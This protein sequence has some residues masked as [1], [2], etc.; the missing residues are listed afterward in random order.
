MQSP[1]FTIRSEGSFSC[2]YILRK[3]NNKKKKDKSTRNVSRVLATSVTFKKH[4][5]AFK[6]FAAV[7][8]RGVNLYW[9]HSS[10]M[11]HLL[12]IQTQN[13]SLALRM[14]QQQSAKN[15]AQTQTLQEACAT[16]FK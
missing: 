13:D 16:D 9:T 8:I 14:Q 10:I 4:L 7:R 1:I 6:V 3:A 2:F 5:T 11:I 15:K 12:T